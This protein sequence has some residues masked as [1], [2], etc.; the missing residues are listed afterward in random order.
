[1]LS[2]SFT[3][4]RV[5][6]IGFTLTAGLAAGLI[7][8]AMGHFRGPRLG[9]PPSHEGQES[10]ALNEIAVND[11]GGNDSQGASPTLVGRAARDY[12]EKTSSG[13]ALM[14][15]LTAERF[16]LK[17]HKRAP[18]KGEADG[19]YLGMS[20]DQNLN[21]WFDEDGITVRPTLSENERENGWQLGF[22]LTSY[23][24]G[25][26]LIAASP[27]VSQQVKENRIE[28]MRSGNETGARVV[29]WYENQAAGIEQGFTLSA[30]PAH[31]QGAAMDEPL[32]LVMAVTGDLRARAKDEGQAIV[33]SKQS[34]EGV[35][36][37]SK[38]VAIDAEGKK[39]AAWMETN[40][41]GD[42]DSAGC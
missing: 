8:L 42:R 5:R 3:T 13:Q 16:G 15:A 32:R 26:Q 33:L 4:S 20:H 28:Y 29:E 2:R 24:Y 17:P 35:L 27:I 36:S 37:Y 14:K 23:G 39:L 10:A 30:R 25:R 12:L 9:V 21:A 31:D 6:L 19:G 22:R 1:M 38:L 7:L 34:G 18:F 41:A 40:D 11:V